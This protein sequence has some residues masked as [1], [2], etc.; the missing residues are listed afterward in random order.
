MCLYNKD[1]INTI[2]IFFI[3][4]RLHTY[5]NKNDAYEGLTQQLFKHIETTHF[6]RPD[7]DTWPRDF[8]PI[9]DDLDTRK[10]ISNTFNLA[11][12]GKEAGIELLD[13][14]HKNHRY[15]PIWKR[16]NY[17]QTNERYNPQYK[18]SR[19]KIWSQHY[20]FRKGRIPTSQIHMIESLESDEKSAKYYAANLPYT[21]G[22]YYPYN[23]DEARKSFMGRWIISSFHCAILTINSD[24]SI[25]SYFPGSDRKRESA[26]YYPIQ[27][28]NSPQTDTT[29]SKRTLMKIPRILLLMFNNREQNLWEYILSPDKRN[30]ITF[31]ILEKHPNIHLFTDIKDFK[32]IIKREAE[33][34]KEQ[35]EITDIKDPRYKLRVSECSRGFWND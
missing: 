16:I 18:E 24:G 3:M 33:K 10:R 27:E 6:V 26:S 17:Y 8:L 4:V 35:E 2:Y 28:Q 20:F 5:D 23:S 11:L 12:P 7:I 13:F 21:Q 32:E 19:G 25:G 9:P 29:I 15:R 31:T 30:D 34:T 14:W 1:Y 22:I